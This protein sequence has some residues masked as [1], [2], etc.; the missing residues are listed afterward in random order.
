MIDKWTI[1]RIILVGFR[2][3]GI[4]GIL[5]MAIT[6]KQDGGKKLHLVYRL[7]IALIFTLVI[8]SY[9]LVKYAK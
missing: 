2:I 3:F 8:G 4:A 1:P 5:W 6:G 9:F 7:M